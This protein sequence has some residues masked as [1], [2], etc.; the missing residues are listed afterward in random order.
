MIIRHDPSGRSDFKNNRQLTRTST[1]L[2][3]H[4]S[5]GHLQDERAAAHTRT[6]FAKCQLYRVLKELH[7]QAGKEPLHAYQDQDF[8]STHGASFV[9]RPA[10]SL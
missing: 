7:P 10:W 3:L 1:G 2:K 9:A 6:D 4:D 8:A 5:Q